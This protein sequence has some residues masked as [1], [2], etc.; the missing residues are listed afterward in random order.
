MNLQEV[1]SQKISPAARYIKESLFKS[2]DNHLS[3]SEFSQCVLF[4][5]RAKKFWGCFSARRA[6]KF[7]RA[8]KTL[9]YSK[10]KKTLYLTLVS[11]RYLVSCGY[12]EVN[13]GLGPRHFAN[14]HQTLQEVKHNV[15]I[16]QRSHVLRYRLGKFGGLLC[17]NYT[18]LTSGCNLAMLMHS[19]FP[20]GIYFD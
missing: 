10:S 2:I 20:T 1:K 15:D 13:P 8:K 18:F 3:K 19:K 17:N 5:R 11:G 6:E 4:A 7:F 12:Q 16:I 14:A 9:P